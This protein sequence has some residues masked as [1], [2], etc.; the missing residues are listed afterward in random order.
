MKLTCPHCGSRLEIHVNH[1][2]EAG[3]RPVECASCHALVEW[4]LRPEPVGSRPED[5]SPEVPILDENGEEAQRTFKGEFRQEALTAVLNEKSQRISSPPSPP[6]PMR[7]ISPIHPVEENMILPST[8]ERGEEARIGAGATTSPGGKISMSLA[9]GMTLAGMALGWWAGQNYSF[10][11]RPSQ[12]MPI[13]DHPFLSPQASP[14]EG[15]K[16]P[17]PKERRTLESRVG[18]SPR[19]GTRSAGK[20]NSGICGTKRW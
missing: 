15:V 1:L 2:S 18:P 11:V 10:E 19:S 12:P 13:A 3:V 17:S 6:E 16:S 20:R 5:S 14:K 7:P 4:H 9:L 8:I